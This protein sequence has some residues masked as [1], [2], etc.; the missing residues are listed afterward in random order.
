MFGLEGFILENRKAYSTLWAADFEASVCK[1]YLLFISA[2]SAK[3]K[4][5]RGKS[6]APACV[7]KSVVYTE[8]T[9]IYCEL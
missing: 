1:F 7:S 8:G 4:E 3:E 5:K 9:C 6:A 2:K